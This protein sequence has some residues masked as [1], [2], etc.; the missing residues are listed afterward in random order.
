MVN[1]G[2]TS[3]ES[4][5]SANRVR[6][7]DRRT[8]LKATGVGATGTAFA[9]CLGG[10][11]DGG[12]GEGLK[13]GHLGPMESPLGVGSIRSAKM[14]ASSV[15]E[16]DGVNGGDVEIVE[17]NTQASPSEAQSVVEELI[18][19][20]NVDVLIGVFASEVALS[21]V[22]L[23]SEMGVPLLV[24]G[25]AS[26]QVTR[27]H[28]GQNYDKYK[29]IF[30]VGPINS[31]LQAEAMAGYAGYLKEHH[32]WDKL[33]FLRDN[34]AWT[35]SF[36]KLLPGFLNERNIDVVYDSALSI[37]NPDLSS[38]MDEV[39]DTEADYILRFFA[40]IDGSPM[41]ANWHEGQYDFGIEGIHVTGM[42]PGYFEASQGVALY[43][44]TAQTGAAGVTAIT[45]KTIPFVEAYR[46]QFGDAEAPPNKAPMY[47]GFT[48]YDAVNIASNVVN[49]TGGSPTEN[50][51]SFVDAMLGVNHTGAAGVIEFYGPDSDYPHDLK[52]IRND[53]GDI[54]NYPVTQWH[55][56]GDLHCVYPDVYRTE[57]HVQP[58]WMR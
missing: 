43:E 13:V 9:G 51:D 22:D 39:A 41:L 54:E 27:D 32:G 5:S 7:V 24:T 31:E 56:G 48:T 18:Q 26:P 1:N 8:F 53:E 16:E 30:R 2:R 57:D 44:T 40:H 46:D 23:T 28:A 6:G 12:G 20:E 34:A 35:T 4:E 15:N 25:S 58:E 36:E 52:E 19:Q 21:L 49:D 38:V 17:G 10:G 55:E 42:F 33:A 11:G 37:D 14:A 29:N 50:L 47:M 3:G 45:D